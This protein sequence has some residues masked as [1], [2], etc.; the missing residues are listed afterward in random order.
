[1]LVWQKGRFSQHEG[2]QKWWRRR[3]RRR[4]WRRQRRRQQGP[5]RCRMMMEKKKV[6]ITFLLFL[7]DFRWLRISSPPFVTSLSLPF[8]LSLS[9][10]V[11]LSHA[12][13][14]KI[15]AFGKK[16]FC[17]SIMTRT[18]LGHWVTTSSSGYCFVRIVLEKFGKNRFGWKNLSQ[19]DLR[20][21]LRSHDLLFWG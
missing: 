11:S 4:Q 12:L 5:W 7:V 14:H 15:E 9:L 8:S 6:K 19:A 18:P 1:M 16:W 20:S 3:R 17:W 21:R 13:S 2:T 10:S